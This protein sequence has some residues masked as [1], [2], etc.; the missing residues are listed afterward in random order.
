M[1]E[2]KDRAIGKIASQHGELG[3]RRAD[4]QIREGSG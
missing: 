4:G 1:G 3:N 2:S